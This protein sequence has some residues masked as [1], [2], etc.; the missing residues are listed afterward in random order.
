[1]SEKRWIKQYLA[2]LVSQDGA[3]GLR[4]D[5]AMISSADIV[6]TDTLVEGIHFLPDDPIDTV[7]WKLVAVNVSDIVA[8]GAAPVEAIVNISWSRSRPEEAFAEFAA[9]LGEALQDRGIALIGGD[10]VLQDGA[11]TVSLTLTG[12]TYAVDH[13]PIRR[14][15]AKIGDKIF[16]SDEIGWGYQGLQDR[17][18]GRMTPAAR[19][20]QVPKIPDDEVARLISKY[21]NAS[22]DISDGLLIDLRALCDASGVGAEIDLGAIPLCAETGNVEDI[23]KLVT[24]GDDYQ[25]LITSDAKSEAKLPSEFKNIGTITDGSKV[26]LSVHGEAVPLPNALGFDHH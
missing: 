18:A 3:A 5:V 26:T 13:L 10:T 25:C 16:V 17:L 23:L 7:A 20:Y 9:A 6:T 24:G 21:A 1:M 14:T 15:G 2:P 19:R 11:L 22:M 8:K 4:D 12:K